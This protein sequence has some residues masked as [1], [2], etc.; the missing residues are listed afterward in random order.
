[1]TATHN[2]AMNE[3]V[4]K[5]EGAKVFEIERQEDTITVIPVLDLNEFEF[6]RIEAGAGPVLRLLEDTHVKNDLRPHGAPFLQKTTSSAIGL[7][8]A[9]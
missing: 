8:I 7:R 6:Q 5:T 9:F 2:S 3:L 1:M 4:E